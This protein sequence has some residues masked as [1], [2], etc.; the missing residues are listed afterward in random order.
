[1]SRWWGE[2]IQVA[3]DSDRLLLTKFGRG[4]R[5]AMKDQVSI[6][7]RDDGSNDW[8]ERF[9]PLTDLLLTPPWRG[10]V[11]EAVLS[12]QYCRLALLPA[13]IALRNQREEAEFARLRLI[14]NNGDIP[15]NWEIAVATNSP[16][17]PRIACAVDRELLTALDEAARQ[18]KSYVTSVQPYLAAAFNCHRRLLGN[19]HLWFA[20]LENQRLCLTRVQNGHWY[21]LR[22]SRQFG[23]PGETLESALSHECL[24]SE[25]DDAPMQ[26]MLCAPNSPDFVLSAGSQWQLTH[27][28]LTEALREVKGSQ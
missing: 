10:C 17:T 2:R 3:I 13:G 27:L 28:P 8:S 23:L 12:H 15:A 14:Q 24:L 16:A 1:M 5:P 11:L 6:T 22:V 19:R 7:I 18:A 20:T 21:S 4:R 25:T 26:V 9:K